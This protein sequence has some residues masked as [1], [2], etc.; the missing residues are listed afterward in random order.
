[1]LIKVNYIHQF[2]PKKPQ[3]SNQ[4]TPKFQPDIFNTT[5]QFCTQMNHPI[6]EL[7][8]NPFK[9]AP[10][11]H[12]QLINGKLDEK[13]KQKSKKYRLKE[14]CMI[15]VFRVGPLAIFSKLS[16]HTDR[17]RQRKRELRNGE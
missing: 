9:L 5:Q 7:L 13:I 14:K 12:A 8:Q 4:K 1:M 3:K 2:L 16:V 6:K 11:S 10:K 15:A 17:R